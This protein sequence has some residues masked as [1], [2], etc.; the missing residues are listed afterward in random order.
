MLD[1]TIEKGFMN[2]NYRDMIIVSSDPKELLEKMG[3]Y[4]SNH[5]VKWT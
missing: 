5:A 3:D 2:K 1:H 4:T